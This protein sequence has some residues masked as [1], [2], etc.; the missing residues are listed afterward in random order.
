MNGPTMVIDPICGMTVDSSNAA[1]RH[2]YKGTAYYFCSVSCLERFRADPERALN[3]KPLN[4]ITMPAPRKPLPMMQP[5]AQGEIDPVCGMTVQLPQPPV[6]T[7]M[8]ARRTTSVPPDVSKNSATILS[9][10]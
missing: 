6:H 7:S 5:I 3:K 9:I 4:V 1:G 10:T 8:A 2:D